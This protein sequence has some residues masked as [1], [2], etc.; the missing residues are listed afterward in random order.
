MTPSEVSYIFGLFNDGQEVIAI[1]SSTLLLFGW[2]MFFV[3]QWINFNRVNTD[4]HVGTP[5]NDWSEDFIEMY[6]E[7]NRPHEEDP[8]SRIRIMRSWFRWSMT[9][10]LVSILAIFGTTLMTSYGRVTG[11]CRPLEGGD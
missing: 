6:L 10:E 1:V 7:A 5:P 3:F 9:A 4:I 2:I 8:D 11:T